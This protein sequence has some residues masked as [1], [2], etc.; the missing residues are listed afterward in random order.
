MTVVQIGWMLANMRT[1]ISGVTMFLLVVAAGGFG[2]GVWI[3]EASLSVVRAGQSRLADAVLAGSLPFLVGLVSLGIVATLVAIDQASR[4]Q[5]AAINRGT[6]V[7]INEA[8][9]A[10]HHAP[11]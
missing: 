7:A 9:H 6:E 2:T 4:D 11:R 10:A 3:V 5:I 8:R 1:F